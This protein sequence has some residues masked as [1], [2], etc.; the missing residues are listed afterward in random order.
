MKSSSVTSGGFSNA[1]ALRNALRRWA[2]RSQ[3]R[4]SRAVAI[5]GPAML[6][7]VR[8]RPRSFALLACMLVLPALGSGLMLD[9]YFLASKLRDA[10]SVRW[11]GLLDAFSFADDV[12][13]ERE[14]GELP[15]WSDDAR[16]SS[17]T[18]R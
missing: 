10:H 17:S 15:Y 3:A 9:D 16:H 14:L 12:Q 8:D 7:L 13:N 6:A 5:S 11:A 4:G 18:A 1:G 2:G